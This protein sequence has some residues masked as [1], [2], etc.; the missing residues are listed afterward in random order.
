MRKLPKNLDIVNYYQRH[1]GIT[2]Q[3]FN[4]N[5]WSKNV[6]CPLPNHTDKKPS[7]GFNRNNGC[8]KCFACN[9]KGSLVQFEKLISNHSNIKE[10]SFE[11]KKQYGDVS[12]PLQEKVERYQYNLQ[13]NK[14]K[15][16]DA[17]KTM[18]ISRKTA[19]KNQLG[20][21]PKYGKYEARLVFPIFNHRGEVITLKKYSRKVPSKHKSMFERGGK[22]SLYGI[23]SINR[24]KTTILCAGEKDKNVGESFLGDKYNF[25]T[26]TGGENSLPQKQHWQHTISAL[27]D[28]T[29]VIC[30]DCD[31]AGQQGAHKAAEALSQATNDI[32]IIQWP[33]QFQQQYPKGDLSDFL[34]REKNSKQDLQHLIENAQSYQVQN[35]TADSQ[36]RQCGDISE[37]NYSYLKKRKD[38]TI[39][40]SNFIILPQQRIWVDDKE[41]VKAVLKS[42]K[43]QYE[44]VLE[45]EAWTSRSNFLKEIKSI[46]L[47]FRGSDNDLQC[48]QEI[49]A[50]YTISVCKGTRELGYQTQDHIFVL[51]NKVIGKENPDC[52][53]KFIPTKGQHPFHDM[54]HFTTIPK[55]QQQP[56]LQQLFTYLPKLNEEAPL[57]VMLGWLFAVPFKQQIMPHMRH[58]PILNIFGTR[59]S[60]KTSTASLLWRLMGFSGELFSC[61]QS[62]FSWLKLLS[63]T[64]SLP[65]FV[66]EYKPCDMHPKQVNY[67]HRLIRRIYA[68]EVETRGRQDQTLMHYKL[69][70]PICI[71]GEMTF[72]EPA[73]LERILPAPLSFKSMT[74]ERKQAH[75]KLNAMPLEAFASIYLDWVLQ[76]NVDQMLNEATKDVKDII[77]N[78]PERPKDNMTIA[79]FGLRCMEKFAQDFNLS[80]PS[81][82]KEELMKLC[83]KEICEV[84]GGKIAL[85]DT[86]EKLAMLAE[87][88]ILKENMHFATESENATPSKLYL[89]LKFCLPELKEWG[90]RSGEQFEIL[91]MKAYRRMF[92]ERTNLYI[93]SPDKPK[94][95]GKG[96][97]RCV[98]IDMA[99]VKDFGLDLEGFWQC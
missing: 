60:G 27:Q 49:V 73:V 51:P 57:A 62:N 26:F 8:F 48:I 65:I 91:D 75:K 23:E 56:F 25:V 2:I 22:V 34:I 52:Q 55:H 82:S 90:K 66:D 77:E 71:V 20:Y 11:L 6:R 40:I 68:G 3:K 83:E 12:S 4:R 36:K 81:L 32:K 96:T 43:T 5:G 39:A 17:L 95:I 41:A 87:K 74:T 69:Q 47:S 92:K 16:L 15:S 53:T 44:V 46:D 99:K 30:Y 63:A 42:Q 80:M 33:Q 98:V 97:K 76:Q 70:A 84:S 28:Q 89:R 94:W 59:G 79:V 18:G 61:T 35:T 85:D 9:E 13:Q 67:I 78:C 58:F 29:I 50:S 88:G 37:E 38:D 14:D 21:I 45:R 86:L 10:A 64:S 24:E 7:F 93:D 54:L 1:I 19:I 72:T 31:A